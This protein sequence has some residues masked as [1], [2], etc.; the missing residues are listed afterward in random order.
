MIGK[1]VGL[2]VG[3]FKECL[4]ISAFKGQRFLLKSVDVIKG[5]ICTIRQA[6]CTTVS[7]NPTFFSDAIEVVVKNRA[8][9]PCIFCLTD[10]SLL[11]TI[12]AHSK[13]ST[14]IFILLATKERH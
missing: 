9:R 8:F 13:G 2:F 12:E 7:E 14:H 1:S 11:D 6:S 10:H 3:I 5:G 4:F